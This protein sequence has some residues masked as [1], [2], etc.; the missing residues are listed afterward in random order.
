MPGHGED[1][2][3]DYL[4]IAEHGL[5]GDLRT[6]ALIGADGRIDWFCFPRFD[7]P[8]VFGAI[9]DA[10]EGGR[11]AIGPADG[12]GWSRQF[13]IPDSNVLI[14]R[15]LSEQG[16]VELRDFMPLSKAHDP[17]HHTRI[18]RNVLCVRGSMT[19]RC[20]ISP[21]F[22]YGRAT[23][24]IERTGNASGDRGIVLRSQEL[25]LHLQSDVDMSV[26]DS[27]RDLT[28]E[29]TLASGE[30]RTFIL[31]CDTDRPAADDADDLLRVTVRFWQSWISRSVYTGRWREMVNRSALT[32]KLLT[33]EPSG[34]IVAAPTAGLPEDAGGVRNWDY[35]YVW[36]RDAAFSLYALLRLGFTDEAAAF[37]HWLT[38]RFA[39]QPDAG[40]GPLRVMY[41]IDGGPPPAERELTHWN[42]YRGSR[43][44]RIG[45]DAAGQLQLDIY[46]ELID[47]VYLF[48]KYGDG[49]SYTSWKQLQ[50]VVAWL[51]DNWDRPDESI[52]EVRSEPRDHVYSRLM[53]W[54]AMERM[55]RIS[56]QRGLPGDIGAWSG[57][58]DAIFEQIMERGWSDERNAF[59]QAYGS[60][61]LDASLLL[62]SAVKFLSPTDERVLA[63]LEAIESSLVTDALVFRYDT[64]SSSDSGA[65]ADADVDAGADAG[66]D[67]S[68]GL[69]GSEGT[70]SMCS[71]W[72][73]ETL[74]RAGRL[75]EARLALEKMFTYSNHLGLFAEQIGLTGDQLGNFPQALTH[76]SL[77]SAA[78]NLDRALD[79]S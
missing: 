30:S 1:G 39:E 71:F 14:T 59:V 34:A 51:Q 10:D 3:P 11:W 79:G 16:V 19:L 75:D 27:G 46:G 25:T 21:R 73:V 15:F 43:P 57:T 53:S 67:A 17:D 54:V 74:T 45:N 64:G 38:D 41:D 56:R 47:S 76:L 33:H 5:I 23:H 48:N 20:D 40:T 42:G 66:A 24:R 29:F 28:G 37:M 63:T 9:L 4:P 44:V 68:D 2:P 8:S 52:W 18:V 50:Q 6:A 65:D 13:Y 31:T 49:I 69:Q 62:M 7:S 78:I 26:S 12:V 36:I 70:F 58:R 60:D 72:Y 22:D 77:I 55:I 61:E 35:R 32:L